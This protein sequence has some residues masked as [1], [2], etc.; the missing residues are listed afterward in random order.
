MRRREFVAGHAGMVG[1]S[2]VPR[3]AAGETA[4]IDR[5]GIQLYTVRQEFEQ[6][7]EATLARIAEIGYQEVEF[8]GYPPGTPEDIRRMLSRY[9]LRAPSSHVSLRG[10]E[11]GADWDV[12]LE[13]AKAVGHRYV[14]VPSIPVNQRRTL[15][16]WKRTAARFNQAAGAA[17]RHGLQFCYHNHAFEFPE[18]EGQIPFDVLLAETDPQLVKLQMDLYW[19]T[20]G[21]KD[22]LDYFAKWPG[23]F[24]MV[25][26]KD[27]DATPQRGF[28]DLGKGT[29]DFARIFRKANQ[30]GIQ[31]YFYEQ[32]STPG[33]A[34]ESAGV[35]FGYLKGLRF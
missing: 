6:N 13:R 8:A 35:A 24:P 21:G 10:G 34:M 26:V 31:H 14:T 23:R 25:H 20:R 11:I 5:I 9:S 3:P 16:D 29:I 1:G 30:A 2:L 7:P 28:A 22:P 18:I 12:V 17:Q 4:R 33:P 15:D 32:D 27:M 19:I